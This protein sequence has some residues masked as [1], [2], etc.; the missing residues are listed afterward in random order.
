MTAAPST[1]S[2]AGISQM[3]SGLDQVM[4]AL[5]ESIRPVGYY[6]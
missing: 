4:A 6:R 3:P 1:N 2:S 5:G